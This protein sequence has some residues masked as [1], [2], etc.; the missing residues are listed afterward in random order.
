MITPLKALRK[1]RFKTALIF[2]S[3]SV[4]IAAIFLISAISGGVVSM[5]SS[6]LKTD[7]D[8]IVTQKGIADTFFSDINRSVTVEISKMGGVKEVSALILGAAPVDPLPIV[9]IYGASENRFKSYTLTKGSYPRSGEVMLGSKI[10]E[11]LKHPETISLSKKEFKVSGVFKSRIGFEDGG[12]VMNLGDA[13]EVFHKSSSIFLIALDDLSQSDTIIEQINTANPEM[14]AKTTDGFIDS[15]NQFKIIKTSSDVIGAMAFLMGILG[16]VSMMSMVV[17]DRKGEFGIMRSIGLSSS[18]IILK[19]LSETL[20]IAVLAYTVALGA[21]LGI[22]EMIEHADKF[23]GYINGEITFALALKV[24][25]VSVTMALFGTLLPAI[26]ASRI[27]P[28][29]LIQRG[30]A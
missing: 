12:V 29:S 15:Y 13:G 30:G 4:S 19:L 5:Y 3:M 6:M 11:T 25:I 20:I 10:Y 8:I 2:I 7:G 17:N 21:S 9:G 24:F 14:E 18:T 16:I 22:L 23:Q 27:D 26:Y 1:N 28:M